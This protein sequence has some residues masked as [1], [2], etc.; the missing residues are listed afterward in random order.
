MKT[1]FSYVDIL[2]ASLDGEDRLAGLELTPALRTMTAHAALFGGRFGL[3]EIADAVSGGNEQ[4]YGFAG[5][6][7]NRERVRSLARGLH[8]SEHEW[9]PEIERS[10]RR[11]FPDARLD[12][13]AVSP[14]VGYDIGIGTRGLVCVNLN[15]G[16]FLDDVRELVS[17]V[18]HETA[19]V[20]FEQARGPLPGIAGLVSGRKLLAFLD[21][22]IQYEGYGVF[23]P[24][25][26]RDRHRLPSAGTPL[27]QDYRVAG[28]RGLA[29]SLA[30]E[31]RSLA[32]DLVRRDGMPL[33]DFFQRGFGPSRLPH[34]LGYAM[35]DGL[36]RARGPAAAQAAAGLD[37]A[38]FI[39]ECLPLVAADS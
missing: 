21:H 2:F 37:G 39:R 27:Q 36:H 11:L 16:I 6:S 3:A 29:L 38:D 14:V 31:Y 5:F 32:A 18:I 15:T 23:A 8:R 1:D 12:D 25:A 24:A 10:V 34:R 19:H 20:A 26:F 7:G 35:V 4:V 9:L 22:Y 33:G 28:D 17:L 13:V 30:R